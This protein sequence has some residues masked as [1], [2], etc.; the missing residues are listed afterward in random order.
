MTITVNRDRGHKMRHTV[1]VRQH[2]ISAD[3]GAAVGSEDLRVTQVT[4]EITTELASA[5][6]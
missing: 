4:T 3:E 1:S 6:P 5:A 2:R